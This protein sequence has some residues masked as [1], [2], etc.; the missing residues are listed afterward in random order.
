MGEAAALAR[1][2]LRIAFSVL[3]RRGKGFEEISGVNRLALGGRSL[4]EERVLRWTGAWLSLL[5]RLG[6]KP[7]CLRRSLV[8]AE[9]L[10]R[11]GY[12]ARVVLGARKD[13]NGMRGHGWVELEG[14]ALGLAD[15][16]FQAVWRE[17]PG[18]EGGG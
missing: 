1:L 9:V 5:A 17:P 16:G 18:P 3:R 15:D 2:N 14:R 13:G 7:G 6:W 11:Q 10:R 4:S 12:D 8:L